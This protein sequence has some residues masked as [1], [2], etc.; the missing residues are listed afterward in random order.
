MLA[1][2]HVKHYSV[3]ERFMC[4][5][6]DI[7]VLL[8]VHRHSTSFNYRSASVWTLMTQTHRGLRAQQYTLISWMTMMKM[9]ANHE[10]KEL[11]KMKLR[12]LFC[13][14]AFISALIAVTHRC[15]FTRSLHNM[16]CIKLETIVSSCLWHSVNSDWC[17]LCVYQCERWR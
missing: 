2:Q 11:R 13:E 17:W 4:V 3:T 14:I 9:N 10:K 5:W 15:I 8:Y 16:S 12:Q 1:H 6:D 7:G